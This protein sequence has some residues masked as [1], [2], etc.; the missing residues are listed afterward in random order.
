MYFKFFIP[1]TVFNMVI[2]NKFLGYNSKSLKKGLLL[3]VGFLLITYENVGFFTVAKECVLTTW[4]YN[5]F[6]WFTMILM[7]NPRN[8]VRPSL[9]DHQFHIKMA[10][11]FLGPISPSSTSKVLQ[12]PNKIWPP[13]NANFESKTSSL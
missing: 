6:Y 9:W 5:F 3:K 8:D 13:L 12:G 2:R 7:R 10:A 1:L 11:K 4:G